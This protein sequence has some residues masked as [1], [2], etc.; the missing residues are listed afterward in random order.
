MEP[1]LRGRRILVSGPTS[2]VGLPVVQA[3]A[4]DNE[5]FGL[6]RLRQEADRERLRALGVTPLPVDL[7]DGELSKVPADVD[8]VLHFA[9][10]KSGA[11]DYDLRANAEG[12]GRLLAHCRGARAF[13][14]VSSGGVYQYAG[15]AKPIAEDGPLG[16]N[17][18]ALLPTYSLSKIAAESVV[19]FAA[20]EHGIPTTIARLSVPYGD[21]G[22]WPWYHLMMMKA[23]HPVP[24]HPERPN[25][26]NPLH[27]D[28]LVAQIPA[29]LAAA[30]VPVTTLNWGGEPA[31]IEDWCAWL[32]ELTGLEPRFTETPQAFGSLQLDLSRLHERV[33]AARVGW[34]DGIRRMVRA[35]NPELLREPGPEAA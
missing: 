7:A 26:Y 3:L 11:F 10:V 15:A 13:L 25:L 33:P 20:R 24:V 34:R 31:S 21:H 9:V 14:H 23:G 4:S 2:Q 8:L 12:A 28:D 5:V 19:R 22:G 29:L 18:R 16:D 35:R 1:T 27:E 6:A 17:H 30:S 32:G